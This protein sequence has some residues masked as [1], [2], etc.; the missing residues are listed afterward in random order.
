MWRGGKREW[1][2]MR[3]ENKTTGERML[4]DAEDGGEAK[5]DPRHSTACCGV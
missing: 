3:C 5:T 1:W 2:E 4:M